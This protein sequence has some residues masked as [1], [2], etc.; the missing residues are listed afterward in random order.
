MFTSIENFLVI[1]SIII[2]IFTYKF[3][4]NHKKNKGSSSGSFYAL[5]F[6]PK[7]D[8]VSNLVKFCQEK[9]LQAVSIVSV[10]GSLTNV[11]LR[12]A[13]D[14]KFTTLSGYFEI[15]SLVGTVDKDGGVHL[16]ISLG[17]ED[18]STIS[19]HLVENNVIIFT[20]IE[21]VILELKD[22]IFQREPCNLS[23]YDELVV[24]KR[25]DL[26]I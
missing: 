24:K 3:F 15:V 25:Q 11:T 2:I 13:N 1:F 19:G 22:Y 20:T 5:R 21:L 8:L 4:K 7:E 18:G 17:R 26:I 9:K 14:K 6:K 23:S 10:V 12:F 16:H